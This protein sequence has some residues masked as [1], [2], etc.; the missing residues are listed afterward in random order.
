MRRRIASTQSKSVL[1]F[2]SPFFFFAI[3]RSAHK[4]Y[5]SKFYLFEWSFGLRFIYC[6]LDIRAELLRY[7]MAIIEV[8]CRG[9]IL[10]GWLT[11]SEYV[12]AQN[13]YTHGCDIE[14][15]LLPYFRASQFINSASLRVLTVGPSYDRSF[16]SWRNYEWLADT[17]CLFVNLCIVDNSTV[18]DAYVVHRCAFTFVWKS[19]DLLLPLHYEPRTDKN[20]FGKCYFVR[21]VCRC[22]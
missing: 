10:V 9:G 14:I 7:R 20:S 21:R 18:V 11:D 1:I 4:L 19:N 8:N 16:A 12:V 3:L 13:I 6:A 2:P 15:D 17:V 5:V 22:W